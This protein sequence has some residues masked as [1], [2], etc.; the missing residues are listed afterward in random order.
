MILSIVCYSSTIL[1]CTTNHSGNIY[2][3]GD[4]I[5][6][7]KGCISKCFIF[8]IDKNGSLLTEVCGKGIGCGILDSQAGACQHSSYVV[9]RRSQSH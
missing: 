5:S 4:L 8:Q 6:A 7:G 2:G 1:V 3:V 9:I